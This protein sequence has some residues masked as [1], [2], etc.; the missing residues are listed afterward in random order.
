[1]PTPADPPMEPSAPVSQPQ[2]LPTQLPAEGAGI[3]VPDEVFDRYAHLVRATLGVPVGLVSLV[4]TAGQVFPGAEGLPQPW[5]QTRCT[6]LSHS[7]CQYV[8][9]RDAPLVITDARQDPELAGNLA[10]TDIGVIAYAGFPL[11]A[12]DGTTV[13]SLCAID[14]SPRVWS[15][16]ELDVLSHL[17]ATASSELALRAAAARAEDATRAEHAATAQLR[18]LAEVALAMVDLE[19][20]TDLVTVIAER[21]LAALGAD[22]GAVAVHDLA[23]PNVLLSYVTASYGPGAQANYA[24]LPLTTALP[25][26]EAARTGTRVLV[27]DLAA[28]RAYSPAMAE[29]VTS[30]GSQAFASVPLRAGGRVIAVLTAGW[31]APQAFSA[32]QLELL[33][34]FAAQ[35]AQALQRLQS[36]DG[37]RRS[38]AAELH[39]GDV[40]RTSAARQG[41]LVTIAQSLADA[42]TRDDVLDVLAGRGADLLGANGCGICL[43]TED[44]EHVDTVVTDSYADVRR[45]V[46]R[47]R[48]D[49]PL[50]A[51]RAAATGQAFYL[52]DREQ[53]EQAFPGSEAIY[54]SA[55]V[56]A[57]AAV[58]LR[59]R[60]RL[61]G[62]LSVGFADPRVFSDEERE[63]LTA[64]AVLTAQ[65]LDRIAARESEQAALVAASGIAETL[66]RSMLTSPPEP[67]HLQIAVRYAASATHAEVGG[68]WYD[69]F[70]TADGLTS[71]VIGD[72]TGHDMRAASV[73][74]QLRNLVR[75]IG[76][77]LGES[78][79][80]VLAAV[81]RAA[82]GLGIDTVATAIVAQIEV[83]EAHHAAGTRLLRWS[84]AGHLP[85]L[86]IEAN[87]A[88]QFLEDESDLVLGWDPSIDRHD[89]V[90]VLEPGSTVLLYTDGLVERRGVHLERGLAWLAQAAG[91]LASSPGVTVEGLCDGLV[92]LVGDHL[93]D[94]VALLALRAHPED[95]P[96][97]AEAGPVRVPAGLEAAQEAAHGS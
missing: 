22:G 83:D 29:V 82:A 21:G 14:T 8:V 26:C 46:Q 71:L 15:E 16:H 39:A 25:V 28:C 62:C 38:A 86:L 57:S 48:A 88:T 44:G 96:R 24:R 3:A 74:G 5:Q 66:Q 12:A 94:D 55:G 9:A 13:G 97:P 93:D 47:T 18:G 73:M 43:R 33:E 69:A 4:T 59:A 91:E 64:F 49:F 40:A 32:A 51:I 78:P 72:V 27:S 58:P 63:L 1:M 85:P 42:D 79:A 81:D 19:D 37:E 41:A 23:E 20:V 34:A 68:D 17:V 92:A 54:I 35:C 45:T 52:Y 36:R 10:I 53:T 2:E 77:T 89:H 30:T 87:G 90:H 75:G 84:N 95:A 6:G 61:L 70:I 56:Q 11:H 67:D 31:R 60:G 76:F 7:F 65:A 80:K 50:P